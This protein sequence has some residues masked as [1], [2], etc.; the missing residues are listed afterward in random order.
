VNLN[1][2]QSTGRKARAI[3]KARSILQ[4]I[5]DGDRDPY[6]GYREVYAVYIDTSG[7]AEE[8]KPLF[9]PPRIS[10]DGAIHVDD[11]FRSS[12]IASAI[13]WLKRNSK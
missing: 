6:E 3:E 9:Q 4:A 8:L 2:R 11:D 13:N 1:R 7:M 5:V 12:I 10:P